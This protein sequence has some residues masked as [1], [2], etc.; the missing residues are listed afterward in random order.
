[1]PIE[2][3][4][5]LKNFTPFN[6]LDEKI[7]HHLSKSI[8][9]KTD[10]AKY[11]LF[12]L[13]DNDTD[14]YFLISG[15]ISLIN[16]NKQINHIEAGLPNSNRSISPSRPRQQ[17]AVSN[18]DITYFTI[19]TTI[20]TEIKKKQKKSN[21]YLS[22]FAQGNPLDNDGEAL[23]HQFE[24]ELSRGHFSLPSFPEIALKIRHLIEH[25]D[26]DINEVVNLAHSDPG[27]AAKLIKT[28]NSPLY[29]GIANCN[30]LTAA[31]MRLGL[32][33]TKQLV[34]SFAVLSLFE[35]DSRLLKQQM[36]LLRKKSIAVAA[37]AF[38]LAKYIPDSNP[39]EALL[40]GL[41]QPLGKIIVISYAERFHELDN[42][43][44]LLSTIIH[45][46]RSDVG[47]LAV[48][49]WGFS[50]PLSNV[51]KNANHLLRDSKGHFDY[52]DLIIVAKQLILMGDNIELYLIDK[53]LCPTINKLYT[54]L[55]SKQNI[56]DIIEE[57][58]EKRHELYQLLLS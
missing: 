15:S 27:I 37:Y 10:K 8:T 46:L 7:L 43:P 35:A 45:T 16:K 31:V 41:L 36:E 42:N 24:H 54:L 12:S 58:K 5:I 29:R 2:T 20:L 51:V 56:I 22:I 55:D 11:T 17:T 18:T 50:E 47:A 21:D 26:C 34:T 14:D 33:T 1:M 57:N 28:A 52:C 30:D 32:T 49:Q 3:I 13:G 6:N 40:A 53:S 38:I 44:L 19:N 9:I 39:E 23:L 48:D 4:D 25:H